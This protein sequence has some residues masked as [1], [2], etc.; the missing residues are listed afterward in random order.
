MEAFRVSFIAKAH[1]SSYDVPRT[2][3]NGRVKSSHAHSFHI[4]VGCRTSLIQGRYTWQHDHTAGVSYS[5]LGNV[6]DE[7]Q[8]HST[9]VSLLASKNVYQGGW[10]PVSVDWGT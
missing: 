1:S 7:R 3:V 9:H 5:S 2:S 4:L 8:R 6:M 10:G